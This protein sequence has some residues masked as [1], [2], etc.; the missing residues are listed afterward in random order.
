MPT[1]R[2]LHIACAIY[3]TASAWAVSAQTVDELIATCGGLPTRLAGS[4]QVDLAPQ[5]RT[6][7]YANS[8]IH[9]EACTSHTLSKHMQKEIKVAFSDGTPVNGERILVA[10]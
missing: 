1:F 10:G 2:I 7:M 4:V 6:G 9:W 8:Q 3:L 5:V